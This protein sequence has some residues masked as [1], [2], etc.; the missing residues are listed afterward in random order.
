MTTVAAMREQFEAGLKWLVTIEQGQAALRGLG[1]E[2]RIEVDGVGLAAP[3]THTRKTQAARPKARRS[4]YIG[5]EK[6]CANPACA[7]TFEPDDRRQK[8]CDPTCQR[9]AAAA[10]QKAGGGSPATE[11]VVRTTGEPDQVTME[12]PSSVANG[13]GDD[14]P[15]S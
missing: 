12:P 15:L 14:H 11:P 4:A 6:I 9:A 1:Y 13:A 7:A 8:F 10:R 3:V 2:V 5:G